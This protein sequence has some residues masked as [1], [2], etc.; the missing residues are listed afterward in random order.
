MQGLL[1]GSGG[2]GVVQVLRGAAS[3][4]GEAGQDS[5]SLR[6]ALGER[7]ARTD[8]AIMK[9]LTQPWTANVVL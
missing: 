4:P 6:N 1:V 8:F 5:Y 7:F 9:G 3:H 2:G